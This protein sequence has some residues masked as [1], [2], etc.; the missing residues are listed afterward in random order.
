MKKEHLI[1]M[2]REAGGRFGLC[3]LKKEGPDYDLL[4]YAIEHQYLE[5]MSMGHYVI[6]EKGSKFLRDNRK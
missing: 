5:E 2:L 6:T 3:S 1:E 4:R